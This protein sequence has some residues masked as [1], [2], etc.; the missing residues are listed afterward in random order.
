MAEIRLC[1]QRYDPEERRR[2]WA[3]YT[4]PAEP[5]DRVLDLLNYVKWRLDG[6]LTYR[7]SCAH[8]V[9]GSDAMRIN[10]SNRLACKQLVKQYGST[11]TI[12]PLGAFPVIKDL[13]VD[14]E[15]F[16][17]QYRS[18]MPYL[19]ADDRP[20]PTERLQSPAERARY[21]DTTKCI[22]CAACTSACPSYWGNRA[23]IGPA[24]I[25]N[26]HRFLFDSRDEARD[27]RLAILNRRNGV[28]RCR[29]IFNCT[30]ACPRGIQVEGAIGEVKRELLFGQ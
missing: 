13:V 12:Q 7:R 14:L 15:P 2:W 17:A 18:I 3:E 1:I 25:V 16:F 26:A 21:D 9:C 19:V 20:P 28:W 23:Y 8:G 30:E 10:G 5:T 24:A 6:T 22:L 27:E 11:I 4:V 29:T